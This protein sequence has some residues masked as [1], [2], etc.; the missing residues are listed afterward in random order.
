[1]K[2]FYMGIDVSKG[3]TDFMI[4]NSKK[5]PVAQNFQLDDTFEGN[6]SLYKLLGRFLGEHPESVLFAGVESTGG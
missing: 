1:M 3:Y 4:L 5:Q 2:P 6:Q